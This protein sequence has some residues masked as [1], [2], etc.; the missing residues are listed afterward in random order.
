MSSLSIC[1]WFVFIRSICVRCRELIQ[2]HHHVINHWCSWNMSCRVC[3]V[4]SIFVFVVWISILNSCCSSQPCRFRIA[5]WRFFS[6]S[7]GSSRRWD[8]SSA[9]S[10]LTIQSVCYKR[11][12]SLG[13]RCWTR[14][15]LRH[16]KRNTTDQ[17]GTT[18][19]GYIGSKSRPLQQGCCSIVSMNI[20]KLWSW[21]CH[22]FLFQSTDVWVN[23]DIREMLPLGWW[24]WSTWCAECSSSCRFKHSITPQMSKYGQVDLL[25]ALEI[26]TLI[27]VRAQ[28]HVWMW[29]N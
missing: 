13:W 27:S 5:W 28:G 20:P 15:F 24:E 16:T 18:G 10:M 22:L 9:S 11:L 21:F 6:S 7:R 8:W 3:Q 19:S 14:S 29:L 12:H 17:T 2:C 1:F 25:L 23:V 4:M 26:C